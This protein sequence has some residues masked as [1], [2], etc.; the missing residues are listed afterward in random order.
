[1]IDFY[2]ELKEREVILTELKTKSTIT[3]FE[4]TFK[5]RD[6]SHVPCSISAKLVFDVNGHPKK[7][8]GS[9]HDITDRKNATRKGKSRRQRQT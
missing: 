9:M 1:M 4:I 8:I 2:A 3:D 5:N 6:G 7:I